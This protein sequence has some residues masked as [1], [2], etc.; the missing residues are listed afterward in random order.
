M[1][2]GSSSE[3]KQADA[4]HVLDTAWQHSRF[5]KVADDRSVE[6][7]STG[8]SDSK[9]GRE[10]RWVHTFTLT[11]HAVMDET[12]CGEYTAIVACDADTVR[13]KEGIVVLANADEDV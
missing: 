8:H 12:L 6:A 2:A 4:A 10:G 5:E 9:L 11:L 7:E 3:A 1:T 13:S